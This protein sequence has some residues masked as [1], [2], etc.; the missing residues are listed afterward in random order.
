[1]RLIIVNGFLGSGK[2]TFIKQFL[3]EDDFTVP[4]IVNEFGNTAYD[5]E[6][7]EK[8]GS[9]I[10]L[11]QH[12]SIFCTC[13]ALDFVSMLTQLM[14]EGHDEV[15]VE[16]S[17]FADPTGMDSLI[18]QALQR[19]AQESIEVCSISIVDPLTFMKLVGSMTMLRRQIEMA[20]LILINKIDLVDPQTVNNLEKILGIMNSE[21]AIIKGSFG[22]IERSN[23]KKHMVTHTYSGK[24]VSK[25]DLFNSELSIRC[26]I[27][28]DESKIN[29]F[30]SE[31]AT[32]LYRLKG[33]VQTVKSHYRIEITSGI[34]QVTA[35]DRSN[36]TFTML[37][38]TRQT[39][40]IELLDI[41]KKYQH[42]YSRISG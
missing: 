31:V 24:G 4:V 1:M 41:L 11:I 15:L 7:L 38:S 33:S 19:T 30:L 22:K 40:Q 5:K 18:A 21:A 39:S 10:H 17:G 12:G 27:W 16:S 20:D 28:P 23:F 36:G 37:Y 14:L 8:E 13:K 25:K 32:L 26:G 6:L 9:P 35:E 2:T 3:R 42:D 29:A 34:P